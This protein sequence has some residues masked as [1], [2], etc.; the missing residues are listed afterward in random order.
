MCQCH[1]NR[2]WARDSG[3]W[4]R[5]KRNGA[6]ACC[7]LVV[8]REEKSCSCVG[9]AVFGR[10]YVASANRLVTG[11]GWQ[12]GLVNDDAGTDRKRKSVVRPIAHQA[13]TEAAIREEPVVEDAGISLMARCVGIDRPPCLSSETLAEIQRVMALSTSNPAPPFGPHRIQGFLCGP[14][15]V[16]R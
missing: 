2:E 9:D 16:E 3:R 10:L 1:R 14:K 15:G 12:A 5:R 13:H 7:D 4:W 8:V 11:V 6:R